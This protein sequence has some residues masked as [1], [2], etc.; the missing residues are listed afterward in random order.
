MSLSPITYDFPYTH[1]PHDRVCSNPC[2]VQLSWLTERELEGK[3]LELLGRGSRTGPWSLYFQSTVF[4]CAS[5]SPTRVLGENLGVEHWASHS[6]GCCPQA[7]SVSLYMCVY[8]GGGWYIGKRWARGDPRYCPQATEIAE[9]EHGGWWS[10]GTLLAPALGPSDVHQNN[11]T[12]QIDG[13]TVQ[14]Q[15]QL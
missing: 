5:F 15:L 10:S 7:V 14:Q 12:T 8:G 2:L 1:V 3:E 6:G 9:A 13:S 4:S 11:I